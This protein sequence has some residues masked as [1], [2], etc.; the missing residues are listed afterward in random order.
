MTRCRAMKRDEAGFTLM[1]LLTVCL[2]MGFVSVLLFEVLFSFT[3]HTHVTELQSRTV[4]LTRDGVEQIA[5]DLRAANPIDALDAGEP[6]STYDSEVSFSIYCSNPGV[7]ACTTS[8]LRPVTYR[9]VDHRLERVVAGDVV[10]IVGPQAY[11]NRPV[12][13]RPGAV[14]NPAAHKVFR[15]FD[16]NGNEIP[17]SGAGAPASSAKFRDCARSVEITL[18]VRSADVG[19]KFINLKT[20]IDLRNWNEVTGCT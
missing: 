6:L 10:A 3:R 8:R 7:G 14:I 2:I 16:G 12:A 4:Q 17:T 1:E 5:R 11:T 9:V 15:Y 19:D 18:F 20:R 13:E